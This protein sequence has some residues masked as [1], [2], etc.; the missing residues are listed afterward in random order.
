MIIS[1]T[2]VR[3]STTVAVLAL[4]LII[5][6]VYCY[7]VLP[8]ESDPDITIPNVFVSTDYRGVSP[9]DMETAI[10]IEIEKKLKGLEGLKKIQ[11]VS[12][13]GHSSINVEFVTGTDIDK[14]L[15]D[16]KDK[17][18][19]AKS[20]LPGDLEDDPSVFEINISEMPIVVYS[21]SGTCGLPCLKKIADDLKDEIEGVHGRARGRRHRWPRTGDQ[22]GGLPGKTRLLRSQHRF[23]AKGGAEREPQYL[24]RQYPLGNGRFQLRV[25]GEFKTPGGDLRPGGGHP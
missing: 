13:E 12:S 24:R 15:Q 10:T 1:D 9:T 23:L 8:R 21:L 14:A 4:L 11:S 7:K 6:G 19:E 17:V 5:F 3:K 25:P 20:D 2:A 22:G 16:V 18:D